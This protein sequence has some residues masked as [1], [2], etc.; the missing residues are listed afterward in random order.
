[1]DAKWNAAFD[2][3]RN[4]VKE[5][6]ANGAMVIAQKHVDG[7]VEMQIQACGNPYTAD[8]NLASIAVTKVMEMIR[9]GQPSGTETPLAGEFK[10]YMGGTCA[11]N[12]FVAFSG[13]LGPVDLEIAEIGLRVLLAESL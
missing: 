7:Q 2:V 3:M 13:A 11:E 5:V 6:D 12:Y 9:T 8:A 10:G 1:M 4:K